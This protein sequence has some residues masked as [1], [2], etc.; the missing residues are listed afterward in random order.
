VEKSDASFC[1]WSYVFAGSWYWGAKQGLSFGQRSGQTVRSCDGCRREDGQAHR[2]K[3]QGEQSL[4]SACALSHGRG[5]HSERD[6]ALSESTT[7]NPST[8][9]VVLASVFGLS[10]ERIQQEAAVSAVL[11]ITMSC[12]VG[13]KSPSDQLPTKTPVEH[14]GS[15]FPVQN[16]EIFILSLWSPFQRWPTGHRL[17]AGLVSCQCC[18]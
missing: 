13:G 12:C 6:P 10:A 11:E 16:Q 9:S 7:A 14:R 15:G 5:A 2:T 18:I 1:N 4:Q 8:A 3:N 17:S